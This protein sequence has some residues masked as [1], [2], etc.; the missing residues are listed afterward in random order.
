MKNTKLISIEDMLSNEEKYLSD[1]QWE[2]VAG[3][4]LALLETGSILMSAWCCW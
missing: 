1:E 2:I 3:N 4:S